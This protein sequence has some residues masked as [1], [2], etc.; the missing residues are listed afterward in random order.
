[1]IFLLALNS[2]LQ[3]ESRP[4]PETLVINRPAARVDF[5]EGI[6]LKPR[7]AP[8]ENLAVRLAPL[9]I[10]EAA[11]AL[12]QSGLR[13]APFGSI[14]SGQVL[15]DQPAVYFDETQ[16]EL[17]GQ[18]YPEINFVW[19]SPADRHRRSSAV[20]RALRI[21]VGGDRHPILWE[22]LNEEPG[23]SKVF[24]SR[25]WED[26]ARVEFG[27][28]LAGRTFSIESEAEISWKVD[29]I[30]AAGPIPMGPI[31]YLKAPW[32]LTGTV[33]CRCMPAEVRHVAGT[34][35]YDLLPLE[36]LRL[37]DRGVSHRLARLT[38]R[39]LTAAQ[40]QTGLRLPLRR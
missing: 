14:L 28:P 7:A 11:V 10:S 37:S 34:A 39:R 29:R 24:V 3:P 16:L 5:A 4:R 18:T 6:L 30:L 35:E 23:P 19:W 9:F 33:L 31:V 32:G 17:A 25:A 13:E 1:M 26:A 27:P 40:L 2:C 12:P 8:W 21:L 15:C 36:D 20:W 22:V 38:Q